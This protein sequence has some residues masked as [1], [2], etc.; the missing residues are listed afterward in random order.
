[1]DNQEDNDDTVSGVNA[2]LEI[3]YKMRKEYSISIITNSIES[4]RLRVSLLSDFEAIKH[5]FAQRTPN[6]QQSR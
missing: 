2:A 1:M 5:S 4:F 6:D 3:L